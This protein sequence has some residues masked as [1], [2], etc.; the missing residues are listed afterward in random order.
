M[1]KTAR[2]AAVRAAVVMAVVGWT[3]HATAAESRAVVAGQPA[4]MAPDARVRGLSPRV[5]AVINEAAAQSETFR[6]QVDLIAATD[7]IVYV[8]EGKC[9][10]GVRACLLANIAIAGSN[11]VLRIVVDA[12]ASDRDLMASIGHEL[13]HALEVLGD[14]SVRSSSEM[15]LRL[16]EMCNA[17]GLRFETDAAIRAGNAV[18]EELLASAAARKPP[19][20]R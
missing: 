12:R 6:R 1:T 15:V 16:K 2:T 13:R 7:G 8:A 14:P 10:Q 4:L 5:V 11:R 18:R 17:C 9:G 3:S 19:E 20:Q